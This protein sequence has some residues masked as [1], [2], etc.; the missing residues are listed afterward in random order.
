MEKMTD[1]QIQRAYSIKDVSKKISIPTGT[2]RQWEK[3]LQ[4]LL[5]IPRSKQGARFYTEKEIGFLEKIKEMRAN[6]LSKDMIRMLMD[7]HL[8]KSSE[9][10]SESFETSVPSVPEKAIVPAE[11]VNPPVQTPN[12]EELY[13]AMDT[14][15]QNMV[16]EIKDVIQHSRTE[17]I[18]EIKN[19]ISQSNLQAVQG[20]SK[21][22]QR[23]NEKRKTE[24]QDLT[25]VITQASE[26]TSGSFETISET[27]A[28]ASEDTF[29]KIT[30]R[31]S[32]S[33]STAL[34]DNKNFLTKVS[35]NVK[36]AQ[37]EIRTVSK[38][39]H[40]DQEYFVDSMNQ[41]IKELTD[42]IREREEA[43]HDMVSSF[44]E[45][46]AAKKKKKWWKVWPESNN[47]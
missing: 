20:L 7:K 25:N 38:S 11:N 42:V 29:E 5:N 9:A 1:N 4:G 31:I 10:P 47:S 39:L 21:S 6:N 43:F 36:D 34:K 2:I 33:S 13:A 19:E 23:S 3:D 17:M 8:H 45:A 40:E 30:K 41:N 44:R 26:L 15:K 24:V 14:Y 46:A 37:K 16:N 35:Q 27:I 28:K 32:E 22:I 12:L 18:E